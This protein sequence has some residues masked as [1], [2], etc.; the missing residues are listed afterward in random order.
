MV[1]SNVGGVSGAG[2]AGAAYRA[3][4][5]T[6]QDVIDLSG[7]KAIDF[8]FTD[9]FAGDENAHTADEKL[10][11]LIVTWL[12]SI[13]NFIDANRNRDYTQEVIDGVR[14]EI[15]AGI[16]NIALRAAAN[17]ASIALLRRETTVQRID[18]VQRLKGDEIFTP[19]LL[20]DLS[21]Y[22]AKP[23]FRM[24]VAKSSSVPDYFDVLNQP[25]TGYY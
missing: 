4:Y 25:G 18:V 24:C 15:P 6:V 1:G 10:T 17:M 23:R 16:H 12:L 14:A 11:A 22:P 20:R 19:A 13:K 2:G 7:I 8:D 9:D 21:Q 5:S 3:F